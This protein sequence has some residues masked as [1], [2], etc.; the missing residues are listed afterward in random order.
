[1]YN[2]N[3]PGHVSVEFQR[4]LNI[5]NHNEHSMIQEKNKM[6]NMFLYFFK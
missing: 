3:V 1:M 2:G 6:G 5:K 4:I